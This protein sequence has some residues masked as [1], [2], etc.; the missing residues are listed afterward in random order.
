VIVSAAALALVLFGARERGIEPL[1]DLDRSVSIDSPEVQGAVAAALEIV[2]GQ[3][4]EV[5]IEA[6]GNW[7]VGVKQ[8]REYDAELDPDLTFVRIDY[9]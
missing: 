7:E 4:V 5:E 8:D 6:N 1:F 9:D 2:S 3:V